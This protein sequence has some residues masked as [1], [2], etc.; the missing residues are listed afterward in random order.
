MLAG[1]QDYLGIWQ[2]PLFL[3]LAVGWLWGGGWLLHRSLLRKGYPKRIRRPR[4][5]LIFLLAGLGG[6]ATGA[7]FFLLCL[8]VGDRFDVSLLIPA[9]VVAT[10]VLFAVAFLIVYAM[11][12]LSLPA[13]AKAS[14][15]PM[16]VMFLW[17]AAVGTATAVPAYIIRVRNYRRE[18]CRN[19]F[20]FIVEELY[21]YQQRFGSPPPNLQALVDLNFLEAKHLTCPARPDRKPGYFYLPA[22]L[23]TH[24]PEAERIILCDFRDN[25]PN[26][27]NVLLANGQFNWYSTEESENLLRRDLNA[28][29][30]AA[31]ARAEG[32]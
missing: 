29:F 30:A 5:V 19:N 4:C 16:L 25:H 31:L 17:L 24:G 13:A 10:L 8:T 21:R 12:E 7:V 28:E 32:R 3:A 23:Q 1:L 9:I 20:F 14:A 26:G 2:L 22:T 11:L 27:R 15:V 18:A 6:A